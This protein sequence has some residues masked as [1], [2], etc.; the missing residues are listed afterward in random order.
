MPITHT[1]LYDDDWLSLGICYVKR[2][3]LGWYKTSVLLKKY[4]FLLVCILEVGGGGKPSIDIFI[5]G[6]KIFG[7]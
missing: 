4:I 1:C 3:R 7:A 2:E 6:K 5:L